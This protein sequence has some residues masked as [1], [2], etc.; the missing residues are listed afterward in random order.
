LPK[1][2]AAS[3]WLRLAIRL[4]AL[5]L[6]ALIALRLRELWKEHPVDFS[7]ANGW[8]LALAAGITLAAVVAYGS[9]WPSILRRMGTSPPKGSIAIFLQS[10][11]GK[12]L[13]GSVWQYAGRVGLARN[14]GVPVPTTILS[15]AIEVGGSAIAAAVLG[16]FLLPARLALPLAIA[17]LLAVTLA[18]SSRAVQRL[19]DLALRL[20]ARVLRFP[21]PDLQLVRRVLPVVTLVYVP[22]WIVYGLAFWATG[23]ALFAVP[24]DDIAFFSAAFAIGWL[25]G[26]AAVFA[27]G[28][29]GVREAVLVGLLG[30]RIGQRE[31]IVVAATSRLLL[32]AADLV[33]GGAALLLPRLRRGMP[34]AALNGVDD[35]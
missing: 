22:V 25:V 4:I 26:M 12:Y 35:E 30:P 3:R 19:F 34:T 11:L 18:W 21:V 10:Q 27:P 29:I 15:L 5:A 16:L 20:V 23:R 13:P 6:L 32:T 2:L 1:A 24:V 8:L 9:V 7:A 33:G 28:G 14:R 31:A 17:V